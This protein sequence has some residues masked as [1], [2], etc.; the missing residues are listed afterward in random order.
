MTLSDPAA[1]LVTA[2]TGQTLGG[3]VLTSG[4]NIFVGQLRPDDTSPSLSVFLLNSGGPAPTPY[5]NGGG[6]AVFEPTVQVIIRGIPDSMQAGAA[7]ARAVFG[8]LY[9][10]TIPGFIAI[11]ARES[12]PFYLGFDDSNRPVWVINFECPYAT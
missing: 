7:V 3:V 5:I 4:T 12:Q 8:F 11:K 9:L 10:S 6:H 1:A 2:L